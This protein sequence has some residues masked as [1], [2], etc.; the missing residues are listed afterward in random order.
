M[1]DSEPWGTGDYGQSQAAETK[2]LRNL[3][4]LPPT[5]CRASQNSEPRPRLR[6]ALPAGP[7]TQSPLGQTH[8]PAENVAGTTRLSLSHKQTKTTAKEKK[9]VVKGDEGGKFVSLC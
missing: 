6:K 4:N 2:A 9:N 7:A 3:W 5:G 8:L 1:G